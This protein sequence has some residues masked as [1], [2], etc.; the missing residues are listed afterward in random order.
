MDVVIGVKVWYNVNKNYS[1]RF[2]LPKMGY[3]PPLF[4]KTC[5]YCRYQLFGKTKGQS[6]CIDNSPLTEVV[7]AE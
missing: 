7:M 3:I 6:C 5:L 1:F 2:F 4:Q